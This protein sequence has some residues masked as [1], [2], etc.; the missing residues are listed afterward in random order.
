M[1]T[2]VAHDPDL[3]KY[4]KKLH[5]QFHWSVPK[6]SKCLKMYGIPLDEQL[7][8][9]SVLE[10]RY[11]NEL[12]RA[13]PLAKLKFRES[14]ELP[15]DEI[16]LDH[17]IKKNEQ[18]SSHGYIAGFTIKCALT[19]YFFIYPVKDVT[20]RTVVNE[21]RNCF[22]AVARI[23]KK[24]YADNA[25]DSA[26]IRDFC[27]RN[28][29][30]LTFRAANLSRSVSV[31]STHRLL[32]QKV[33]SILGSKSQANWHEAAWK[34]A[35]SLNCQPNGSTG[36]TPYYLFHCKHPER[37]PGMQLTHRNIDQHW[38]YDLK[39][40]RMNADHERKLRSSDYV[41]KQFELG[42]SVIIRPDNSKN[43]KSMPATVVQDNGGATMIVKLENRARPIP[44]HKGMVYLQK[45]SRAWKR[46]NKITDTIQPNEIATKED[47]ESPTMPVSTRTR[48]RMKM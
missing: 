16:H 44:V 24:I 37:L 21:L 48:S 8:E 38:L 5:D 33:K 17:V 18:K 19:R 31:E 45:H 32:H 9:R 12:Q 27:R 47:S 13:A 14:P 23:P 34:A 28:N 26:T 25:F 7:V 29:I 2:K 42:E 46:L 1:D 4:Y 35:I 39:I 30:E 3:L 10:C 36:F 15:F 22:M 20:T 41:H 11:C 43:A 6:T 40:A